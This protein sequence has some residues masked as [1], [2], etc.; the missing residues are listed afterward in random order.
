MNLAFHIGLGVGLA[1]A[2]GLRPF[3][4]A[5]LAGALGSADILGVDFQHGGYSFL[6]SGAWLVAVAV[7]LA[8][9]YLLSLRVGAE[10]LEG[11][12]VG[13]ALSGLALGV[14]ALLFAG[15]LADHGDAAWPGLVGG[16]VCGALSQAAVRPLI[17]RTRA[18]LTDRAAR[19][20]LTLYVDGAALVLAAL[21]CLLHPLGYVALLLPATLVLAARRRAGEKYAGL[22]ILRD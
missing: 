20:A 8:A 6:Q 7:V 12:P 19:N 10:R 3:L 13:A 9:A 15:T 21:V 14:A 22:R 11:G 18:R 4:P 5:L 16:I 17:M 1:V 2:A